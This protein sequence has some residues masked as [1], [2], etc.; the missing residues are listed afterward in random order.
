MSGDYKYEMQMIAEEKAEEE[1]GMDYYDLP[2]DVQYNVFRSAE[3][4]YFERQAH[5]ADLM[6]DR[7][8]D[9]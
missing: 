8:R 3:E 9:G 5:G 4:E 6:R 7:M 2:A 1:Y